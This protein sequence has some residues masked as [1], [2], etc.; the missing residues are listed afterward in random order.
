ME[1]NCRRAIVKRMQELLGKDKF[2]YGGYK[3]QPSTP[4][5]NYAL[6]DCRMIYADN[7]VLYKQSFY[8]IRLVTDVKDFELESSI[9]EI[10]N[11]MELS[12]E[13]LSDEYIKREHV[14]ASEWVICIVEN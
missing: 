12:W 3:E 14:Q 4:Y 1:V 13:R 10:F 9:E 11:D 8:I 7:K 2:I 5:A 6:D